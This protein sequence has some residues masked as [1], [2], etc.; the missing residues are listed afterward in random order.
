MIQPD[1]LLVE[2]EPLIAS[3]LAT[4]LED[5]GMNVTREG[6]AELAIARVAAGR[7]FHVCIMDIRLPGQDGD[8]A[9][10]ALHELLPGMRFIV[11]TGSSDYDLPADWSEIGIDVGHLFRKPLP[12]MSL[13]AEKVRELAE[14]PPHTSS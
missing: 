7:R 3:T 14:L 1:V 6:S 10:R 8:T 11:H 12:D 5:E 9:I 4:F 13:M 2:D